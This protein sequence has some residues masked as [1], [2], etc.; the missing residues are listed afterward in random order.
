M[1][2]FLIQ[3]QP[4]IIHFDDSSQHFRKTN[5][6]PSVLRKSNFRWLSYKFS[7]TPQKFL[8]S[9]L[10]HCRK[11]STAARDAAQKS[12]RASLSQ[13][14]KVV[15]VRRRSAIGPGE[16]VSHAL[17]SNALCIYTIEIRDDRSESEQWRA[18]K[19]KLNHLDSRS[20]LPQVF[21]RRSER[22]LLAFEEETSEFLPV[23][24]SAENNNSSYRRPWNFWKFGMRK[25]CCSWLG[26]FAVLKIL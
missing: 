16:S 20:L 3:M 24:S 15:G 14:E 17:S 22:V 5:Q 11:V 26:E 21:E 7:P 19:R 4:H 8:S 12:A 10:P 2:F 1:K 9:K 13:R 25:N 23:W 18:R 6:E